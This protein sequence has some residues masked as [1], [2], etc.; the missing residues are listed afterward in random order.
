MSPFDLPV[1]LLLLAAVIWT[2]ALPQRF[3]KVTAVSFAGLV[4]VV[5]LKASPLPTAK[6]YT[7]QRF[8]LVVHA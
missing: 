3:L 2:I 5:S 7:L 1:L 6:L 4:K 8:G